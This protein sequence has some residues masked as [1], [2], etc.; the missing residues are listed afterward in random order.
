[1]YVLPLYALPLSLLASIEDFV[2]GGGDG[3]GDDVLRGENLQ[4]AS[5]LSQSGI[6]FRIVDQV[7]TTKED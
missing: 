3:M 5:R 4:L 2:V 6:P 7:L 1:M